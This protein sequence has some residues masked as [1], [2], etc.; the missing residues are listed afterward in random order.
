MTEGIKRIAK[1]TGVRLI[2]KNGNPP[3]CLTPLG[4][5]HH[6]SGTCRIGDDPNTSVANQYGQIH[7]IS[8]LYVADNSVLPYIG[9]ENLTLTTVAFAIRAAD[10]IIKQGGKQPKTK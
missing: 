2:S 1:D 8:G 10:H 4:D 3:I 7:G 6:D 9:A 5:L